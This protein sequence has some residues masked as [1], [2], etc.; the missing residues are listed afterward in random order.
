MSLPA[1]EGEKGGVTR[2][3]VVATSPAVRAG[4]TTLLSAHP[5]LTVL[6]SGGRPADWGTVIDAIEADVVVLALEPAENFSWPLPIHPDT[7]ARLPTLVVLGDEPTTSWASRVLRAGARA[8]LPRTATADQIVAAVLAAAAGLV[9]RE[10]IPADGARPPIAA[11]FPTA[12]IQSLT[13][14]EIEILTLLAEGLGNKTIAARLRISEHTVKT[15]VTAVFAKLGVSTRAEA[16]AS[17]V[18]LGLLM[19]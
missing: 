18:R 2:V 13:P 16:V 12:P 4:L 7:A 5:S 11:A 8:A 10:A 9:V 6:E 15:H 1:A 3:V 17:A 19:L 14:R